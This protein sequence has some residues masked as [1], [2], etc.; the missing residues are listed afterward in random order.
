MPL[1]LFSPGHPFSSFLQSSG[2]RVVHVY[3][4]R[5]IRAGAK[6]DEQTAF[7]NNGYG[8]SIGCELIKSLEW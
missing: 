6:P 1:I 5:G 7:V 4:V 2:S 3:P 8:E